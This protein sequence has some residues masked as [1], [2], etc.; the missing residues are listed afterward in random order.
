MGLKGCF[1]QIQGFL[2]NN[3]LIVLGSGSSAAYG[4]PLMG[5]LSKEIPR[6]LI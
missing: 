5:E 1:Q 4:L 6:M 2:E 3:P